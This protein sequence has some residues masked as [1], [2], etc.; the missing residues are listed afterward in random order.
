MSMTPDE[1]LEHHGIVGQKWGVR[2]YQNRDGSLTSEGRKRRGLRENGGESKL[3]KAVRKAKERSA[4]KKEENAAEKHESL[5]KYVRNHPKALYKNRYK[6]S[7]DEINKLVEEINFDKKLKDVKD[8]AWQRDWDKV[9]AISTNLGTIKTLAE[10][11]KG[12][13]N[14][15]A[16][17]NNSMIDAGKLNG[18][19][20][21]KIGEK[22]PAPKDTSYDVYKDWL[23]QENIKMLE[24]VKNG[25]ATKDEIKDWNTVVNNLNN[26]MGKNNDKN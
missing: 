4:V 1:Y 22:A 6:F 16:D 26:L 13:Y 12:I 25:T 2:R 5:K 20:M 7:E 19:K 3:K 23:K 8:Q 14:L 21:T 11:A 17:V 10:N 24:K 18:S 9:R 15:A